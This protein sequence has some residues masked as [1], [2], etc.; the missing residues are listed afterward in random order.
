MITTD[1]FG[2]GTSVLLAPDDGG[3]GAAPADS[4]TGT[5]ADVTMD[6]DANNAGTQ[7]DT[8]ADDN[9]AAEIAR[10]KAQLANQKK[11]I[12]KATKEAAQYK[13]DLRA[14]QTAEEVAAEEKKAADEET[15]KELA[16]LRKEVA[17]T[18]TVKTVMSKL[19]TDE[20]TSTTIA[21]CLYEQDIDGA[22]AAIQKVMTAKEKALR[23][24]FSK[25]PAP[26][27][28]N[29]DGPTITKEQLSGMGYKERLDFANKHPEEY[30][31]LMGR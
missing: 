31:K 27:A 20:E 23:M 21:D 8:G 14:R 28:G 12:D 25:I 10:L 5:D 19:G 18:K 16:E 15:A 4:S 24:E 3:A 11:A 13:R 1:V 7:D 22:M 2:I 30:N 17:R 29:S 9:S 6:G 26:S